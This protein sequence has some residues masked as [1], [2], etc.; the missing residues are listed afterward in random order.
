MTLINA[1]STN[2][3]I[4]ELQRTK[5]SNDTNDK[6]F[7]GSRLGLAPSVGK[8]FVLGI[9]KKLSYCTGTIQCA[10]LVNLCCFTKYES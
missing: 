8:H 1:S 7:L 10:M 2:D 4:V 9:Y 5:Y 6:V 3:F